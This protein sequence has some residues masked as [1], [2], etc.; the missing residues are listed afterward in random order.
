MED[1][2]QRL[3]EL[4][5][6]ACS[7]PAKSAPRQKALT[8]IIRLIK[9]RLWREA[10]NPGYYDALQ[11]T[12]LYFCRNICEA[13]TGKRYDPDRASL[14]TWLD[15][16]LRRRLQDIQISKFEELSITISSVKRGKDGELID[17]IDSIPASPDI[18]PMLQD[19]RTW[20]EID[21]DGTL[22]STHIKGHP[23]VNCQLLI[24][25]RLP[26]E[27]SWDSLSKEFGIAI[28]TLSAFYQRKCIPKLHNFCESEGYVN[29]ED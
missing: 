2:T 8:Q 17:I 19:L 18:P 20:A 7:H 27:T 25:R 15:H 3:R 14:I 29:N 16:Y 22:T 9:D 28:P 26:P 13:T 10:A 23:N 6:Q 1:L 21:A 12:W 24:L 11:Q 4:V 5:A